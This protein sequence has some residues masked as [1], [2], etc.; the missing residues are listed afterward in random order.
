MRNLTKCHE[1]LNK[2]DKKLRESAI[3]KRAGVERS[4][5]EILE[6]DTGVFILKELKD[7]LKVEREH[8]WLELDLEWDQ[9]IQVN[10]NETDPVKSCVRIS[11]SIDQTRLDRLTCFS[12]LKLSQPTVINNRQISFVFVNRL[13]QFCAKFLNL[14]TSTVINNTGLYEIRLDEEADFKSIR[15]SEKPESN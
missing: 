3:F 11:R 13:K 10:V 2:L 8:L 9:L 1:L 14:C 5:D 15:F 6:S 7:D 4:L 12:A